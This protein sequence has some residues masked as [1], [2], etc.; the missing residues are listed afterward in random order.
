MVSVLIGGAMSGFVESRINLNTGS[1]THN[2][3]RI[4]GNYTVSYSWDYLGT[5]WTLNEKISATTYSDYVDQP[6]TY[7]FVSY[8]TKDDTIIAKIAEELKTDALSKGYNTAQFVLSFVQNVPYGTDENTTGTDNFPRYP[9]E[10]LVDDV[11][12]CKDHST[13]YVSLMESQPIGV[14]MV[15]LEL[16][17]TGVAVGHMAAGIWA[18]GYRGTYVQYNDEDYYYCETTSPGWQIGQLPP[19]MDGYTIQVLPI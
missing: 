11:G 14:G 12:D 5:R 7:D 9:V 13:L 16:T 15:L 18:T 2:T 19:E 3:Q 17:K 6:K 1:A 10:T 8:V 4:A